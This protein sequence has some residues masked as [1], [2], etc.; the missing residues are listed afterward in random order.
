MQ[1]NLETTKELWS[2]QA[3]LEILR[4]RDN[5]IKQKVFSNWMHH[6]YAGPFHSQGRLKML[7]F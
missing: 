1:N 2:K 7:E 3:E 4:H 6:P 5:A